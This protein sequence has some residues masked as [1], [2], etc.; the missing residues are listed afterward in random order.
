MIKISISG[1]SSTELKDKIH[2]AIVHA[3]GPV[4]EANPNDSFQISIRKERVKN[5]PQRGPTGE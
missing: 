2:M 3:L 5:A 4:A 1:D